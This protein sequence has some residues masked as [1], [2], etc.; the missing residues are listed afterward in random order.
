MKPTLFC[1][2]ALLVGPALAGEIGVVRDG[3]SA[4]VTAGGKPFTTLCT[5]GRFPYLYPLLGPAG[6]NITRH[7]PMKTGVA[8]EPTDHPHH[9]SCWVA[10][11]NVNGV[12]FW[13]GDGRIVL[14]EIL[15]AQGGAQAGVLKLALA[16]KTKEDA[17]LLAET[18]TYTFS[19]PDA[20]TRVLLI[21]CEFKAVADEVTFG[22][23]KEGTFALRLTPSLQLTGKGAKGTLINSAGDR[24]AK[25]WGRPASWVAISGPDAQGRP[26]VVTMADH[27]QN[28]RHPTWWHAR[29]Y[30]LFAANPFGQHDFDKGKPAGSGD[31][32]M[33]KGE[34]LRFRHRVVI[35][36]GSP[37]NTD[38]AK[39]AEWPN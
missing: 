18:R 6:G 14:Q 22:D 10:H 19:E 1:A 3:A 2:A 26:L 25:V 24:D 15:S 27:P 29:D 5:D 11:G 16:W 39:L 13:Q 20:Q 21:D 37:A 8:D 32:K 33:A 4:T 17:T 38:L 30:G 23:T 12:D 28:P 34:I 31:L 9:R 35:F 7:F 36:A